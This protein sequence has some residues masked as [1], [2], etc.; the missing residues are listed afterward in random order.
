MLFVRD[1]SARVVMSIA[2]REVVNS[3]LE[4][5]EGLYWDA[6]RNGL[7]VTDIHGCCLHFG[8]VDASSWQSWALPQR[9]GWVIPYAAGNA[10]LLGLQGGFARL[11]WPVSESASPAVDWVAQPFGANTALRLNDAKADSTGA[12]WAGSLNNDDESR[13]DGCLF[14]LGV[15]G[16]VTVVDTGYT[17]ANG[18]AIRG[19]GRLML[20]T[21][22]GQRTIYAFDLDAPAGRLSSKRVWKRFADDEGYPDGMCFDAEGC[23]WVAHWGAGCISRFAGDGRLLRRVQLPTSHITNVCFGGPGLQRLFVSSARAG[24]SAGQLAAQ[25]LAGSLFEVLSPGATGLPGLP[26]GGRA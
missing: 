19:D 21:D 23:V 13:A 1:Q 8:M 16:Q 15:D 20:H 2:W 17:V 26:F 12:V 24:L 25:P 14:R 4:L 11:R 10:V 5:G 3:Q 6:R 18:P 9:V 22:S 7:W